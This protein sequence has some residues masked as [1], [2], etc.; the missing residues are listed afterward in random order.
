MKFRTAALLPICF[1]FSEASEI[2]L[3]GQPF[4]SRGQLFTCLL[5]GKNVSYPDVSCF[6]ELFSTLLP[7]LKYPLE[8]ALINPNL[9]NF[10]FSIHDTYVKHSPIQNNGRNGKRQKQQ[11]QKTKERL[12]SHPSQSVEHKMNNVVE[13]KALK[14]IIITSRILSKTK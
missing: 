12:F 7:C 3:Q 5:W 13:T 10:A 8:C 2:L 14:H 11:D 9:H 1:A 6:V 4:F